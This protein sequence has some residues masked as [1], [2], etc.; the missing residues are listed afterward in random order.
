MTTPTPAISTR[1]IRRWN[2]SYS[3]LRGAMQPLGEQVGDD[4]AR[5][6]A[7]LAM[8]LGVD[9]RRIAVRKVDTTV[10]RERKP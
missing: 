3:H 10:K 8:E 1:P 5:I 2:C 9:Q 4:P 6:A 7:E